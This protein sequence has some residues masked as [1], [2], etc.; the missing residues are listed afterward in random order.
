[1]TN[2]FFPKRKKKKMS[3]KIIIFIG[4]FFCFLAGLIYFSI[5]SSVLQI[6][7][8][9]VKS[10]KNPTYYQNDQ[11]VKIAE[12]KIAEKISNIIPQ[13]NII[14]AP[15]NEIKNVILEDFPE[16]KQVNIYRNLTDIGL[17]IEIEERENIG[18]WCKYK[19]IEKILEPISTSTEE[20]I[21]DDETVEKII[22][23]RVGECFQI[24]KDGV[25]YKKSLLVKSSSVLNI[26]SSR[27]QSA[28]IRDTIIPL[29]IIDFILEIKEES[30]NIKTDNMLSVLI[31]DFDFISI[32]DLRGTTSLG[33]QVYFDPTHSVNSQIEALEIVLNQQIK[34]NYKN[35]DYVDLRIEGKIYYK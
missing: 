15:L 12:K 2:I 17:V 3:F 9:E 19:E 23:K 16:I 29:E 18:I 10:E 20:N 25:I 14:L 34:E 35:L 4:L 8:I 32:E 1:M 22:E 28:K 24:D 7:K 27:D 26:F 33:W 5:W 30:K 11:I 31:S 13:N 21:E 6:K